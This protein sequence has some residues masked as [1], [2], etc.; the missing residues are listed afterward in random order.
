MQDCVRLSRPS[1][2][3]PLAGFPLER[4]TSS[5]N[6]MFCRALERISADPRSG[7]APG[8]SRVMSRDRLIPIGW[9][10]PIPPP[11]NTVPLLVDAY[12]V[13]HVVGVL[14]PDLAG[15]DLE[16]LAILITNSRFRGEEAVLVGSKEGGEGGEVEGGGGAACG[17][18]GGTRLRGGEGEG[19]AAEVLLVQEKES[20][21]GGV[22]GGRW[23]GKG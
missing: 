16:E 2:D 13:L 11:R 3:H 5:P 4:P 21:K 9:T 10:P 20:S 14:P 6:R 17:A 12:N 15:I 8:E 1:S 22:G 18:A 23:G 7:P 19:A